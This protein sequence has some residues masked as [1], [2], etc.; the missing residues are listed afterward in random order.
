MLDAVLLDSYRPDEASGAQ[1]GQ[2]DSHR[3]RH[4]EPLGNHRTR[5]LFTPALYAL[6]IHLTTSSFAFDLHLY[7]SGK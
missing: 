3:R 6:R 2:W 4:V 5:H 1:S 7:L